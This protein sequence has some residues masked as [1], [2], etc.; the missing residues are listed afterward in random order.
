MNMKLSIIGSGNWGS[1]LSIF[2]SKN[3][4]EIYLY[5][6][7]GLRIFKERENKKYL[8]GFK[9]PPKVRITDDL[10]ESLERSDLIM[11]VVPT[12]SLREA[13]KEVVKFYKGSMIVSATKGIEE[14]TLLRPSQVIEDIL[15]DPNSP[16]VVMSGP[17]IAREIALGMPAITV[18]ASKNENLAERVQFLL[19]TPIFRTY[20]SSDVIGVELGGALKNIIAI[21]CGISDGLGFGSNAKGALITRGLAEISRLGVKMGADPL[22]FSGLSG[23]GDL[24]TT[25]MSKNSRNRYVGEE[26]G[27]GRRLEDVLSSMVMIAEGVFTTRS[28]MKLSRKW[29][30][31]MP[32]TGE[33]Y[34]ILFKSKPPGDGIKSLMERALK[35]EIWGLSE[36]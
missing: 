23:M 18:C 35:P 30:V 13:V 31:G 12:I 4:D 11:M 3:F 24:I 28:V 2:L 27:K 7:E 5:S 1:T 33:V 26:V 32:I 22:T 19:K 21:A 25:A 34:K 9:I 15:G 20:R 29:D 8:P 10:K 16:I 36:K 6:K 14:S 17:N